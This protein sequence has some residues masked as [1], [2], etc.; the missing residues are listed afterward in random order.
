MICK[1]CAAW[2]PVICQPRGQP[3]TFDRHA[4]SYQNIPTQRILMENKQIGSSAKEKEKLSR[5][6]LDLMHGSL[7]C[8]LSQNYIAK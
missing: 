4:V 1:F 2:G 8:L 5:H 3:R 6:V 7:H